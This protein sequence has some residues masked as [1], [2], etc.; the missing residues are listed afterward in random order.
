MINDSNWGL[1]EVPNPCQESKGTE[2]IKVPKKRGRKRKEPIP[3]EKLEKNV[4]K[5]KEEEN[6]E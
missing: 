6:K 1:K 2:D 4:E 5:E 3:V